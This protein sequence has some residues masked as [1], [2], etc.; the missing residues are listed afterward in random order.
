MVWRQWAGSNRRPV[1]QGMRRG[2]DDRSDL[3]IS[4]WAASCLSHL[5]DMQAE[6]VFRRIH[7][8]CCGVFGFRQGWP[9]EG[10][11]NNSET[12]SSRLI[13]KAESII[14]MN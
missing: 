6:K 12:D 11:F 8:D 3:L 2:S 7:S 14:S 9:G 1:Q 4:E 10:R 5:V 13:A